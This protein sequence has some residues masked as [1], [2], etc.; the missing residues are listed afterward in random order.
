MQSRCCVLQ[1]EHISGPLVHPSS[2][3][4]QPSEQ[5]GVENVTGN[6]AKPLQL[7]PASQRHLQKQTSA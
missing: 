2:D 1:V 4:F 7:S 5:A 3:R 6:A